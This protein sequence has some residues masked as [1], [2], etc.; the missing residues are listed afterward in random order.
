MRLPCVLNFCSLL[1]INRQVW[2]MWDD[3]QIISGLLPARSS[4][5][6]TQLFVFPSQAPFQ[7]ALT[8]PSDA[9]ATGRAGQFLHCL[10]PLLLLLGLPSKSLACHQHQQELVQRLKRT[11]IHIYI[12]ATWGAAVTLHNTTFCP[13]CPITCQEQPVPLTP[14]TSFGAESSPWIYF[15]WRAGSH[16]FCT[17]LHSLIMELFHDNSSVPSAL[18]CVRLTSASTSEPAQGLRIPAA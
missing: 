9:G 11:R 15:F 16:C 2:W 12:Q 5:P 1:A 6:S 4:L 17:F 13:S 3:I 7:R 8:A 14:D 10:K 18:P